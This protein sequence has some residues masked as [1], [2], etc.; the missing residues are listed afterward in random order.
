MDLGGRGSL[1][2]SLILPVSASSQ[3]K[4]EENKELLELKRSR[5][6]KLKE[7]KEALTSEFKASLG[8]AHL[9]RDFLISVFRKKV[10]KEEE[11]EGDEGGGKE[12]ILWDSF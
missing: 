6:T 8:E 5:I 4:L 9:F 1:T 2:A 7:T 11:K 10:Q 12:Q 3:P